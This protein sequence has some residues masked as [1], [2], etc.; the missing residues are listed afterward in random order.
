MIKKIHNHA[1]E[2]YYMNDKNYLFPIF[3]F[4]I[5]EKLFFETQYKCDKVPFFTSY[6]HKTCRISEF[7]DLLFLNH[8]FQI[9]LN[10]HPIFL[11]QA[12][13]FFEAHPQDFNVFLNKIH[14]LV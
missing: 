11:N 5:L 14:K 6:I 4:K 2:I 13:F 12:I 9:K 8:F 7:L 3:K 10:C 1:Y